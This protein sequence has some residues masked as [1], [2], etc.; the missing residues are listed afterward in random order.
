MTL[1]L[2]V[3]LITPLRDQAGTRLAYRQLV[4]LSGTKVE[5]RLL[6]DIRGTWVQRYK[7][8]LHKPSDIS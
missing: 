2:R 6:L 1:H 3:N 5:T 7:L 8:R 4:Q